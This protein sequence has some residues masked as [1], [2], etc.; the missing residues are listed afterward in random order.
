M[1]VGWRS[2]QRPRWPRRPV[3]TIAAAVAA[4]IVPSPATTRPTPTLIVGSPAS[5][6]W[7][8][9]DAGA[10]YGEPPSPAHVTAVVPIHTTKA[11]RNSTTHIAVPAMIKTPWLGAGSVWSSVICAP[12]EGGPEPVWQHFLEANPWILGISLAAQLLTSWDANRLEQTVAGAS[13]SGPGKRVDALLETSGRIRALVFAEIK[14]H[15]T[16]LLGGTHYRSGSWPP[17]ADLAGAVV[18][19]QQTVDLAVRAI[20]TELSR[21]G[22]RRGRDWRGR[23]RGAT[24]LF[25]HCWPA[26]STPRGRRSTHREV[27]IIR[28]V[29][30]K[31][32][33]ALNRDLR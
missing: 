28:A 2:G 5:Q 4:T 18:Q 1:R 17:S 7:P 31:P 9:G 26:R 3:A 12:E 23:P 32:L 24:A 22:R 15:R 10:A 20:G 25:R 6:Y 13:V 30:P 27:P 21:Q 33:R 8:R 14:H 16:A 11:T 29:P 19:A